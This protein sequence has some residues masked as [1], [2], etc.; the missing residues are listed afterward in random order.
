MTYRLE[1][2][3]TYAFERCWSIAAL[4]GTNNVA[5]G[6]DEGTICIQVRLTLTPTPTPTLT[7]TLTLTLNPYP[8]PHPNHLHPDG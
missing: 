2:T 8:N 4:K 5:I 1:N 7:L 3:L 6:Y